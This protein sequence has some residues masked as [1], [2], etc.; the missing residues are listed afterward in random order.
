[1]KKWLLWL[2]L[3]AAT[4]G[5]AGE[6]EISLTRDFGS[7]Y[8]TLLIPEKGAQTAALLI[9]GSGPMDRNNN[10]LNLGMRTNSFL[11]LARTLE[12]QGIASLRYDKR[13]IGA[14][15]YKDPEGIYSVTFDDYVSDAAALADYLHEQGYKKIVLI[16]HSEGALAALCAAA[17]HPEIDGVVSLA[18]AGFPID[19]VLQMQLTEQLAM[20]NLP[21]LL[22]ANAILHSL[23]QG[24][25]VEEYPQELEVL[26]TPY[27][28]NY[29][30]SLLK[31][32]PQEVIRQ[33]KAPILIVNGDNDIQIPV[34]NAEAL[35][36]AA[37]E[38]ELLLI[39]GMT[40]PLKQSESRDRMEQ[41]TTVYT[42]GD[43][44]LDPTLAVEVSRF[45]Q[46]L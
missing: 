46:S 21:L 38:A 3:F 5:T 18:G 45:I 40:H 9:T 28:Q 10:A 1:M 39:K 37:P 16:G 17:S 7:L 2:L 32:N 30:I 15:R 41:M 35:K 19:E 12:K 4:A 33:I 24:K 11:Y 34:A 20:T 14:S 8:G 29:W 27:L 22:Q 43:L 26:F 13:G 31:Y 6:R 36:K 44:P 42:N 25:T 23:R